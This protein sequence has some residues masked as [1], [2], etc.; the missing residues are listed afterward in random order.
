[1]NILPLWQV[2]LYFLLIAEIIPIFS[3]FQRLPMCQHVW[4]LTKTRQNRY[5]R[6]L[7]SRKSVIKEWH[8]HFNKPLSH[9]FVSR[10]TFLLNILFFPAYVLLCIIEFRPMNSKVPWSATSSKMYVPLLQRLGFVVPLLNLINLLK[11][12]PLKSQFHFQCCGRFHFYSYL[13]MHSLF[14][15]NSIFLRGRGKVFEFVWISN[16]WS[17]MLDIFSP[18]VIFFFSD[19]LDESF[20][21]FFFPQK[22]IFT[23]SWLLEI[24]NLYLHIPT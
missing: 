4:Y 15:N 24:L 17:V 10:C 21:N 20:A 1:M 9:I 16:E 12:L 7:L 14:I 23:S 18:D 5:N 6:F 11:F 13:P 3:T 22:K 19:I 8:D 2:D